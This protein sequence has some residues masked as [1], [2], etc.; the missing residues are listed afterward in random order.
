[1]TFIGRIKQ[2]S[3]I[4][5]RWRGES[6]TGGIIHSVHFAWEPGNIYRTLPLTVEQIMFLQGHD[7]IILEVV[8][9][10]MPAA[11]PVAPAAKPVAVP[12]SAP[13]NNTASGR[14]QGRR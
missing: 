13:L 7:S 11:A 2:G 1:M 4:W 10:D 6:R 5:N 8:S 9:T 14:P 3:P 12:A